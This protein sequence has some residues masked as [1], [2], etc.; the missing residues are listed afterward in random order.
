MNDDFRYV[1]R[2][3]VAFSD[4]DM[5]GHVNNVTYVRWAETIR[6]DYVADVLG[7]TIDGRRGCI[8]ANQSWNYLAP[9]APRSEIAVATRVSRIGTKSFEQLYEIRD[10]TAGTVAARGSSTLVAF[11]Y[12]DNLSIPVPDEWRERIRAFERVAP[13]EQGRAG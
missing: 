3:R 11:D 10:E 2:W 5:L 9:I 12:V 4:L 13:V 6:V 1:A 7:D 8:L